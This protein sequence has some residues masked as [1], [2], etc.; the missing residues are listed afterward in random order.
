MEADF[1]AFNCRSFSNDQSCVASKSWL[2]L[3]VIYATKHH[4][5]TYVTYVQYLTTCG[6]SLTYKEKRSVPKTKPCG[7]PHL[8]FFTEDI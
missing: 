8:R 3:L 6:K 7:T 4:P 2:V 5:Q 1:D